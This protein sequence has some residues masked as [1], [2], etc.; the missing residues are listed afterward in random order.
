MS[1]FTV[2]QADQRWRRTIF[3]KNCKRGSDLYGFCPPY[4][5]KIEPLLQKDPD[6]SRRDLFDK[7]EI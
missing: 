7:T 4:R 1:A 3:P 2:F 6:D 5:N